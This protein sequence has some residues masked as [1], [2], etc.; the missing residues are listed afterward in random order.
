MGTFTLTQYL[1]RPN[2]TEL[3]KA[4][5][6]ET[7]LLVGSD[8]DITGMFPINI[9]TK[10]ID[11][12]HAKNY[13]LKSASGREFRINQLGEIY[14]DYNVLPGD[15]IVL[16]KVSK[17][18]N[19]QIFLTVNQYNRAVLL[20]SSKGT[21]VV[22][23]ERLNEYKREEGLY[24]IKIKEKGI[25]KDLVIRF[26]ESKKKRTDSPSVTDFY[27][28]TL[29]GNSISSG[30]Y[31]LDFTSEPILLNLKK[32]EYSSTQLSD[33]I[34]NYLIDK[35]DAIDE[36]NDSISMLDV[37]SDLNA[38]LPIIRTKP[39]LLL[40]GISGT[41]KSRIVKEMAYV[42]CPDIDDLQKEEVSPG[43]YLLVEVKPNWHDSTELIGYESGIKNSY[44][45][46]PFIKFLYKAMHYPN[47]P[48]FVCLDEMN[49]APV[50]QYFA[51]FL[52]VLESRK[53][54]NDGNII[55]EP[56]I[57]AD[58]FRKYKQ[59]EKQFNNNDVPIPT[60]G[61]VDYTS[62]E[63]V[64]YMS[65]EYTSLCE[66]GL[67]IPHNL[68]VIGTVNMDET[69]HQFS[70]K[71]IDR[72]MTIEMNEVNF[73]AFYESNKDLGY[74]TNPLKVENFLPKYTSGKQ[75]LEDMKDEDANCLKDEL[76]GLLQAIN[77]K[78]NNTPFKIAYRVQN[79]II[80]Y[81]AAL[82][83][84]NLTESSL[85][86]LNKSIDDILLMKVLPRIEGDEEL[87]KRPL[88]DLLDF[89]SNYPKSKVKI[90]EMLG[91]LQLG[92]FTSFWP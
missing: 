65:R 62:G 14:R 15:E 67:C 44:V 72:A 84:D 48:F 9:P 80:L 16:T 46:T 39:F 21:E 4:N 19:S 54:L 7:Y 35:I 30:S 66:H 82:R 91:R 70:R 17:G 76:P 1:H 23:I 8:I 38:Y 56:L 86:L 24:T 36:V 58:I 31:Y 47:I 63:T 68:I 37:P 27:S 52:S 90:E 89:A 26:S 40:A 13:E 33:E 28:V 50:E 85:N 79:E 83:E 6:H 45:L 34:V 10:V 11:K 92:H 5:T 74:V 60:E 77:D 73:D 87:L 81:F 75:A 57:K 55:S 42:S 43:N 2:L 88:E 12:R 61:C 51:E 64:S 25:P 18:L 32:C 59:L 69:T 29:D 20:N 53:R 78:L 71:V 41:G 49:L 22:N 3:G